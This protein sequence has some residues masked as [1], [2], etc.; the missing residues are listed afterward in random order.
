[1][2]V[3]ERMAKEREGAIE[4]R[5]ILP[6][7][8]VPGLFEVRVVGEPCDGKSSCIVRRGSPPSLVVRR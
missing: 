2:A 4:E 6:I 5:E 7:F 8:P 1:M 3:I